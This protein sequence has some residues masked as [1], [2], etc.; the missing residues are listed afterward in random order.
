MQTTVRLLQPNE[1]TIALDIRKRV[2]VEEQGKVLEIEFDNIDKSAFHFVVEINGMA[3]GCCR[4]Y[5]IETGMCRIGRVCVVPEFRR[6]RLAYKLVSEL[7]SLL[8]YP[9]YVV[10]AREYVMEMYKSLG[11]V[12]DGEPFEEQGIGVH[13]KMVLTK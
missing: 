3:V 9:V 11:Y 4:V 5:E 7:P 13:Y 1:V 10:H 8:P 6:Q 2:F 12:I